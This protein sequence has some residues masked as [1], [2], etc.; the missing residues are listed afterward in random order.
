MTK[1]HLDDCTVGQ[2]LTGTQPWQSPQRSSSHLRCTS[3][4]RRSTSWC[5]AAATQDSS[6]SSMRALTRPTA[7]ESQDEPFVA[8]VAKL[9]TEFE[10]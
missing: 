8:E 4:D 7:G 6:A 9:T 5:N 1:P 3:I 10:R 2:G